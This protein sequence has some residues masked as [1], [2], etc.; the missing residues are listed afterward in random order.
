MA[1]Y[2]GNKKVGVTIEKE[3]PDMLQARVDATNSCY[4]LFNGYDGDN[5][6]FIKGLDTSNA[7]SMENMFYGCNKVTGLDKISLNTENVTTFRNMFYNCYKL[8]TI[9]QISNTS[10]VKTFEYMFQHCE[11]LETLDLSNFDT[12][13]ADSMEYMFSNC[14]I[15][16]QLDL[17][18]FNT[19]NVT[20]MQYMFNYCIHLTSLDLSHFDTSN[21]TSMASMFAVCQYMTDLNLSHFDTSNV[22]NMSS[23]FSNCKA[24]NNIDLSSF[25]T[26]KVTNM[27][28][29]FY[30]CEALETISN[31]DMISCTDCYNMLSYASNIK[32]LYLKN[33]KVNLQI[34]S[35]TTSFGHLLTDDSIINTFKELWDLTGGTSQKLTLSKPSN[36]RTEQIY[37]KLVDV[38]DEMRAEDEYIDNKKP[39][40]VCES[41]DEGAMTLKEYGI[42]KNWQIA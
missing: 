5:L 9:P 16:T 38:T 30:F 8:K 35:G 29:V 21:V 42:S 31:I 2:L 24:L 36:A 28:N 18:S 13:K 23:M 37:V 6:D 15:L 34:G 3:K 25:D 26:R 40:V 11:Q 39:C 7:T 20:E 14:N 1:V 4:N 33:I 22:T 41:T 27:R 32:H 12:S 19:S 17:S 10:N